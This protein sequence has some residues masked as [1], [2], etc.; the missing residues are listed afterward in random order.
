MITDVH[1]YNKATGFGGVGILVNL[2]GNSQTRIDN[3]YLDYNSI[4]MEDPV[5]VHVTNGF[6][7]GGGN[8]V[9]KSVSGR[10]SGLNIVNN[11]FSGD[12]ANLRPIVELDGQFSNIDQVVVDHNNAVGMAVKSTVGKLTVAGNGT[13]WVADFSGT[14]L[15]PNRITYMQY[16][17]YARGGVS[18][19]ALHGVTSV[20]NNTIT[21]ES[22]RVV[23]GMV[24]VTVDQYNAPGETG[25]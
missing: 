12:P 23:D 4:V 1:C 8:V 21:V 2:P 24:S 17:F 6:F 3:C 19:L 10:I 25:L 20:V 16:G 14:L 15:F 11:M 18:G 9:I 13:R 7:L 5:Q 22:D